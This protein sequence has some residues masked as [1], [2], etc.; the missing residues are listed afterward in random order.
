MEIT[1]KR[2]R[3]GDVEIDDAE[4][5][6]IAAAQRDLRAF[7]PLYQ[8]YFDAVYGY[9]RNSLRDP[10]LAADITSETFAR[11][12]KALPRYRSNSFRGWLFTI[13]HNA[14]VDSVR[15]RKPT[16]PFDDLLMTPDRD[17]SPEELV[18]AGESTRWVSA[19]LDRLTE[20]QRQ[21]VALRIAGLTGPEIA[22]VLGTSV[23][24][25]KATQFRAYS[26]LREWLSDEPELRDGAIR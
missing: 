8:R 23:G 25:V 7:A 24:A 12:M 1:L 20:N 13:A 3:W 19:L 17:P 22:D 10:E 16:A 26:R 15:R 14:I 2:E 4:A 11:A 18:L 6:W 9:A 5:R 21:V